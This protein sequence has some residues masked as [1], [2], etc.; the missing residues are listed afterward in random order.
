M[1]RVKIAVKPQNRLVLRLFVSVGV[2]AFF[3]FKA[4][5]GHSQLFVDLA[6]PLGKCDVVKAGQDGQ[7]S[8]VR[9]QARLYR[10][11][12]QA[13]ARACAEWASKCPTWEER[14][15][16]LDRSQLE[17]NSCLVDLK[18][19]E[20]QVTDLVDYQ[21]MLRQELEDQKRLADER[22]TT[23]ELIGLGGIV[24]VG[25]LAA[26]FAAGVLAF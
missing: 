24:L 16:L 12:T 9:C 18:E 3:F 6:E 5:T 4:N 8:A 10:V 22:W 25:G 14:S 17:L 20:R 11:I 1:G 19:C 15:Q 2:C 13:Q 26:G 7:P 21:V 23:L